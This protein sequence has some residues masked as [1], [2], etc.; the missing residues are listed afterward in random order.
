MS[1]GQMHL[2]VAAR[3]AIKEDSKLSIEEAVAAL[4]DVMISMATGNLYDPRYGPLRER[5]MKD[6]ATKAHVPKVV[7]TCRNADH[8]WAHVKQWPS[9]AERRKAI[10]REF[11]PLI[12]R[13]EDESPADKA[14]SDALQTLDAGEVHALWSRAIERRTDDPGGAIT[15]ART[16]LESTCKTILDEMGVEY[17]DGDDLP[18]LYRTT[19]TA[20]TL[21]PD[22]HSEPLFKQVLGGCKSVVEGLGAI[23]NRLGDAHGKWKKGPKVSARHAEL[24]VNL[25]GGMATFLVQTWADRQKKKRV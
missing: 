11:K 8:V 18:K 5:I 10:W 23:R 7:K 1:F 6:R 14:V 4:Q 16:L 24:A 22:Q 20:L 15:A 25:A 19:A 3:R 13:L 21:A 9:Y 2:S 12:E 17:D